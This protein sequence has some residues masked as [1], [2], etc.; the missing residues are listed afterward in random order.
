M[1]GAASIR[2]ARKVSEKASEN[3]LMEK[4]IEILHWPEIIRVLMAARQWEPR[5]GAN[6]RT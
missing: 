1:L 5:P 2:Q 4:Q 3:E 6:P